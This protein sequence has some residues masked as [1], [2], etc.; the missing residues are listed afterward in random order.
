MMYLTVVE[1][2]ITS[3][4]LMVTVVIERKVTQLD[5]LIHNKRNV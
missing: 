5:L 2:T 1:K 3:F 4:H